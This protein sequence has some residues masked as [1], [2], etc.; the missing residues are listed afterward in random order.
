MR[1][2]FIRHARQSCRATWL[3]IRVVDPHWFNADTDPNPAFFL[4]ADQDPYPD[5]NADPEPVPDSG[6]RWLKIKKIYSWKLFISLIKKLHFLIPKPPK[7][8]PS[9]RRSLQPSKWA[10]S[11]SKHENSFIFLGDLCLPGSGSVFCM[12]I[13]I[14]WLKLTR[15]HNPALNMCLWS[16]SGSGFKC[17]VWIRI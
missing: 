13:R 8:R 5:P 4:I 9:Y 2:R 11:T 15:I 1:S 16:G 7:G 10:S 14:Q 17:N 12:R 6:L 3:L